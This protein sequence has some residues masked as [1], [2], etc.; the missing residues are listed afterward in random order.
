MNPPQH[1]GAFFDLDGTL[2]PFPSLEW[3]FISFL[4]ACKELDGAAGTRWLNHFA[5]NAWSD[6]RVAIEANKMHLAGLRSSL[7]DDWKDLLAVRPIVFFSGAI[8]RIR[9]HAQEGHSIFLVSG[10]IE[11]LARVLA[12]AFPNCVDVSASTMEERDGHWTGRL[13]SDHMS[14]DAKARAVRRLATHYAI[15]LARSYA[16]GNSETDALMLTCV[17][18]PMAVNPSAGLRDIAGNRGWRVCRWR[19]QGAA[20]PKLKL[21]RLFTREGR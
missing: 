17:G 1:V 20:A 7:A 13:A 18:N 10:T 8:E 19:K 2:V 12:R 9:W 4:I 11:P 15:D 3:R 6:S 14:G 5:K 21:A 16:Y